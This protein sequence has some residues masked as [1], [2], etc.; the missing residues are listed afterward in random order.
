[1]DTSI[2]LSLTSLRRTTE[3]GFKNRKHGTIEERL[4][5][6][7]TSKWKGNVGADYDSNLTK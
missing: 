2:T 7:N 5:R 1:M 3:T 6:E 4:F